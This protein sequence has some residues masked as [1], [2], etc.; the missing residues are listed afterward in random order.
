MSNDNTSN[1]ISELTNSDQLRVNLTNAICSNSN[2]P[3][4][5]APNGNRSTRLMTKNPDFNCADWHV[6]L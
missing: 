4:S 5:N 2:M 6:V 3:N 1:D